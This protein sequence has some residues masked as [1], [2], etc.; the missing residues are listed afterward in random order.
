MWET[1]SWISEFCDE[2]ETRH[3][4]HIVVCQ[5][6]SGRRYSD[7][8]RSGRSGDRISVG[9][10]SSRLALL[11]IQTP[12]Q[13]VPGFFLGRPGPGVNHPLPSS[14]E[15]KERVELYLYSLSGPAWPITEPI[16]PLLS[17]CSKLRN[18]ASVLRL[19]SKQCLLT[20]FSLYNQNTNS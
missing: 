17:L 20:V 6:L 16:L 3:D 1:D 2:S 14:A 8:L 5:I 10:H 13:W 12:V 11:P 19:Y 15:V 9:P 7:C 4:K 18:G